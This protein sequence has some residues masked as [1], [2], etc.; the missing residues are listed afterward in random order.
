MIL[1]LFTNY[2]YY[3]K[4]NVQS[5]HIYT[6]GEYTLMDWN[7]APLPRTFANMDIISMGLKSA[8]VRKK[9]GGV[10]M[11]RPVIVSFNIYI[12]CHT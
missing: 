12:I 9:E 3:R 11:S 4:K 7:L 2:F 1:T 10:P 8:F 5:Y 6:M